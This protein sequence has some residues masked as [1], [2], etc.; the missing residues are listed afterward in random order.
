FVETELTEY[1]GPVLHLAVHCHARR[2]VKRDPLPSRMSSIRSSA[3]RPN[4]SET[5]W[6]DEHHLIEFALMRWFFLRS[7]MSSSCSSLIR[8][9]SSV[10][11]VSFAKGSPG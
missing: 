11:R 7:A 2:V 9:T 3:R 10:V 6:C 1:P 5:F 8:V 4:A